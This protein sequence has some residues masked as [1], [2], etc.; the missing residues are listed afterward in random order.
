MEEKIGSAVANVQSRA[1]R[2][3]E[4]PLPA[5]SDYL[6]PFELLD[7]K[8]RDLTGWD[9]GELRRRKKRLLNELRL[10]DGRVSWLGDQVLDES[11]VR[12]V[13]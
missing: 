4:Q 8:V 3:V 2:P 13:L 1:S 9:E 11:R 12:Q 6:N 5:Y 7:F 10:D